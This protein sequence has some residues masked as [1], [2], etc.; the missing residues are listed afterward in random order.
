MRGVRVSFLGREPLSL[1]FL[2]L[3]LGVLGG[4][5]PGFLSLLGVSLRAP[6]LGPLVLPRVVGRGVLEKS[7]VLLGDFP[8]PLLGDFPEGLL[9]VLVLLRT[10]VRAAEGAWLLLGRVPV[11]GLEPGLAPLLEVEP[12]LVV[13]PLLGVELRTGVGPLRAHSWQLQ[14]NGQEEETDCKPKGP[15]NKIRELYL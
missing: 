11:P 1:P 2:T 6:P 4:A 5:S 12:L 15:S 7:A 8:W 3:L 13:K 10:P 14:S 9:G